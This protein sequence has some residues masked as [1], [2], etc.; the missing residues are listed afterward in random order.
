M[1]RGILWIALTVCTLL[2]TGCS[3][4]PPSAAAFMNMKGN[5]ASVVVGATARV[6]DNHEEGRDDNDY[7]HREGY[8]N[9]DI[10]M[11]GRFFNLVMTGVT[12]ENYTPRRYIGGA[13]SIC[14]IAGMGRRSDSTCL[15]RQ[16][17]YWWG[18]AD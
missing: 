9:L 16:C 18:D 4:H 17:F 5:G 2:F 8:W 11:L 15:W 7:I 14:R 13:W 12:L 10:S 3:S 6:G 1:V